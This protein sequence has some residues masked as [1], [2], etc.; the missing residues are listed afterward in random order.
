MISN[1]DIDEKKSSIP[2]DE[3]QPSYHLQQQHRNFAL[4]D[5]SRD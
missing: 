1:N 5:D 4:F 3:G 2:Y